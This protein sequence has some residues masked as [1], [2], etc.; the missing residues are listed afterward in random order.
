MIP[1]TAAAQWTTG[2]EPHQDF[3]AKTAFPAARAALALHFLAADPSS[4]P[5]LG[6]A[7]R[8]LL[9]L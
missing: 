2:I 3:P 5:L 7:Y 4:P 6:G 8:P 9:Q 1:R